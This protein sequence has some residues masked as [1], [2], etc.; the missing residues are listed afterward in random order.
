LPQ[1]QPCKGAENSFAFGTCALGVDFDEL[2][3]VVKFKSGRTAIYE[4]TQQT[5]KKKR[6]VK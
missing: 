5:K 3:D 1:E 2:V 6:I 4:S